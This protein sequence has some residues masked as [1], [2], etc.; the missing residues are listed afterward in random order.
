MTSAL[1]S[2]LDTPEE[3]ASESGEEDSPHKATPRM[4]S[5]A[6]AEASDML[7]RLQLTPE[8]P[9]EIIR[10]TYLYD[11]RRSEDQDFLGSLNGDV[12]PGTET[13]RSDGSS[14]SPSWNGAKSHPQQKDEQQQGDFLSPI[15]HP[16]Q[17]GAR[18]NQPHNGPDVGMYLP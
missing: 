11:D 2:M 10:S 9:Q 3:A 16:D 17:S 4:P 15:F 14:W 13:Q 18:S 7:A 1:L 12:A 6:E 8:V 5:S